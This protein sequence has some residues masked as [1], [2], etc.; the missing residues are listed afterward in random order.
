[1]VFSPDYFWA[2]RLAIS[3]CGLEAYG[4][5]FFAH[6]LNNG[7]AVAISWYFQRNNMPLKGDEEIPVQWYGYI[8]SA[9]LTLALFKL[10]KDKSKIENED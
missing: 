2:L 10:L 3:I 8:I 4:I 6:F 9:I 1:L 7:F 5:L